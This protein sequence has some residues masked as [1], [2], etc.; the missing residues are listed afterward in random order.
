METARACW[1]ILRA[2]FPSRDV[3]EETIAYYKRELLLLAE[4]LGAERAEEAV[5]ATLRDPA[6]GAYF[7]N[8]AQIRAHIPPKSTV[9]RVCLTYADGD[10]PKCDRTG[11]EQVRITGEEDARVRRCECWKRNAAAGL[12][13]ALPLLSPAQVE[14]ARQSPQA[15]AFRNKLREI[16][17]MKTMDAKVKPKPHIPAA[18]QAEKVKN[19][20]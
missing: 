15:L 14:E 6:S 9:P 16:A 11:W 8:V 10:C 1:A 17:G 4:E 13:R 7:P 5:H 20:A 3:G 19:P 18:R 2:A 12:K